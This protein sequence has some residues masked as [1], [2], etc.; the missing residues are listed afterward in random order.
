MFAFSKYEA[1]KNDFLVCDVRGTVVPP[2][3]DQVVQVCD[4]RSGVGADG[5]LLLADSNLPECDL[6]FQLINADG[7]DA[8]MS[9]NG[10]RALVAHAVHLGI[11]RARETADALT[12]ETPAGT[13]R[14][15]FN[16]DGHSRSGV[17]S[18]AMGHA[19]IETAELRPSV[20]IPGIES[21]TAVNVGNP[22][23]VFVLPDAAALDALDL[24]QV[25]P[26]LERDPQFP[27]RTNVEFIVPL[28]DQTLRFRVWERGVGET[29]SCGTG[30]T[31][32]A[33]VAI[34]RQLV[35]SPVE[36]Q[37]PGGSLRVARIDEVADTRTYEL[38]G[39]VRWCFDVR[40]TPRD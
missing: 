17:A 7:S 34:D 15:S 12:V 8:E 28:D 20:S 18:V 26:A 13:R 33:A 38:T 9:G 35:T 23:W 3:A 5:V 27:Y 30:A 11:H 31:A 22:H 24:S 36:V 10:I 4:R 14:V 37:V 1:T 16:I 29:L 19:A 6:R 2:N 21:G 25:G 32:A 39:P 40:W